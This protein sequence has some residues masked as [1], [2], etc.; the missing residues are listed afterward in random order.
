MKRR[1]LILGGTAEARALAALAAERFGSR[2]EIMVSLAGRTRMPAA[3]A[4][5]LRV[6]GFGGAEGL[7]AFLRDEK[8]DLLVDA[9]HP[10]AATI[11]SH[12]VAAAAETRVALVRLQRQAWLPEPGDRWIE[13]VDAA[14]AAREAGT[15]GTRIF[16]SFGGRE[17]AA[18]ASLR[19]KWFLVRRIE[20]PNE[21]LP[22]ENY[23]LTLGRGP[24]TLEDEVE[25]L[26]ARSI[27][28]LVT[29]ASGGSATRAKLDAARTLN[30]PVVMIAQ[31]RANPALTVASV[32]EAVRRIA[33]ALF[34]DTAI[35]GPAAVSA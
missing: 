14:S 18:F 31:P 1:L 33:A 34:P 22:L 32:D 15:L 2:L 28:V 11:S 23:A 20:P 7:A 6:G 12:A 10:F 8:V 29:K 21:K 30:L 26:R 35:D 3:Y 4:G 9:T 13:A 27:D 16:L 17:L 25:L 24:F 5:M 19:D